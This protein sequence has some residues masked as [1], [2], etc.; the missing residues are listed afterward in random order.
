MQ[1]PQTEI[2]WFEVITENFLHTKG[3]PWKVLTKMRQD[4]PIS[5]HGVSLSVGSD[6]EINKNYLL[7]LKSLIDAI[8]PMLVSDHICWTGAKK[9]NLHNLMPVSYDEE[10]LNEL[11]GKIQYIQDF[12]GRPMAF[13]NLSAY[14][15]LKSS[16]YTEWDFLNELAKRSG[17][18]LLLDINNVYVNSQNQ[19]FDPIEYLDAIDD[20]VVSEIHLAGHT[21]MGKFLFD[22]HSTEVCDE[23]WQL[24][25]HKIKTTK[26]TPTLIEWDEDIPEFPIL[27]KE[28][29]KAKKIFKEV[30]DE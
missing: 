27:E 16:T 23:V 24:Y 13:E 29:L 11:V 30:G 3:Y 8:D 2:E 7:K 14:F 10:T 4:Y 28:A 25:H 15:Q 5:L 21:D 26:N 6:R 1:S 19:K 12:L 22:T 20:D 18:K 17:C 9:N